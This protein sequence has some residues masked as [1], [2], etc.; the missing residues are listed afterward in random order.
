MAFV[1]AVG[2]VMV[3]LAA[4]GT[5][6]GG[7]SAG[8]T[9]SLEGG[10]PQAFAARAKQVVAQWNRSPAARVWRTGLVLLSTDEL[11]PIPRDAGFANQHQKEAFGADRFTLTGRLPSAPLAGRVRWANGATITVPLLTAEATFR[12]LATN[13]ACAIAPCGH[14]T[15]TGAQPA[16]LTI[17]TNRGLAT[18]PTWRFT[19]AELPWPVTRAAIAPSTYSSLPAGAVYRAG[20]LPGGASVAAVADGGRVLTLSFSTGACVSGWGGR[21]YSAATAVVVGSWSRNSGGSG[22]CPASAILRQA[23]VRL[24]QPVGTRVILDAGTGLP[25]VPGLG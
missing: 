3:T 25:L 2:L 1:I 4:C 12:Q 24:S 9:G 7:G 16:E 14:L 5:S 8:G 6:P 20:I 21:V 11:T 13:Q 18:V 17:A 15:V 23:Q 22:W 10:G 19:V